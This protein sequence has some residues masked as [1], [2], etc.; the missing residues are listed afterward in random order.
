MPPIG[1][2]KPYQQTMH[3]S[4]RYS[5]RKAEPLS[6]TTLY[7]SQARRNALL[8]KECGIFIKRHTLLATS[9]KETN[10]YSNIT[11]HQFIMSVIITTHRLNQQHNLMIR[12][13]VHL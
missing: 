6:S 9:R 5:R 10:P 4:G 1:F 2:T 11:T 13:K 8:W 3:F 7:R 12:V